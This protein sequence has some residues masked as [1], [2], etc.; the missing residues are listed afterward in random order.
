M[1]DFLIGECFLHI[2][3][4]KVSFNSWFIL[5]SISHVSPRDNLCKA[6]LSHYQAQSPIY[7]TSSDGLPI[8][9]P[10][11]LCIYAYRDTLSLWLFSSTCEI[12]YNADSLLDTGVIISLKYIASFLSNCSVKAKCS[13]INQ[14]AL[15]FLG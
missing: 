13:K 12:L 2:G 11:N 6:S 7:H 10:R 9:A 3:H 4:S 8:R 15:L 5:S 14:F 1:L